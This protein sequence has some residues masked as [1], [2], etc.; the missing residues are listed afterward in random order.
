MVLVPSA[1]QASALLIGVILPLILLACVH[2]RIIR[3]AGARFRAASL[4]AVGL[5]AGVFL[6][7][8]GSREVAD[9]VSG[10]L[11]LATA[12]LFW[13][14]IWSLLAWGFT[15]TL[16]TALIT[17]ERPLTQD[18]WVTAYMGGAGD[19]SSFAENRLRLLRVA[20]MVSM[21]ADEVTATQ[22]GIGLAS[23][24]R[25]VQFILGVR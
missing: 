22:L 2:V 24:V 1:L 21:D 12:I 7:L 25:V 9:I 6:F 5:Y 20:G 3:S 17:A 4:M 10:A 14:V 23:C 19:L 11:L 18:Q 16:L 13:Y 15:L 8:P